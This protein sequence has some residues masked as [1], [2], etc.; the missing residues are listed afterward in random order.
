MKT[1][2]QEKYYQNFYIEVT[3]T[4]NTAMEREFSSELSEF[5][6]LQNVRSLIKSSTV[7][8]R[9]SFLKKKLFG[10]ML[11]AYEAYYFMKVGLLVDLSTYGGKIKFEFSLLKNQI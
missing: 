8:Q 5:L 10:R 2:Y 7:H 3:E 1:S 11:K 4:C 6:R 9:H